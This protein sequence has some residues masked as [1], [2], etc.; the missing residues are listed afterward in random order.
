MWAAAVVLVATMTVT[1]CA[2]GAATG[3]AGDGD[4][5]PRATTT[6]AAST[7]APEA[8]PTTAPAADP[9]AA[10]D[11][12]VVTAAGLSLRQGESELAALDVVAAP[13]DEAVALLT[14]VLGEPRPDGLDESHCRPAQT[15]WGWGAA[16]HIGTPDLYT[17]AGTLTFTAR[18]AAVE[19][20]DGREVR[21]ETTGGLA[22]GDPIAS[23]DAATD[24]TMKDGA[25]DAANH[26]LGIVYDLDRTAEIFDGEWSPHGASVYST[27]GVIEVIRSTSTLKDFC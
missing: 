2:S 17:D 1:G 16:T 6:P 5:S 26:G 18:D 24:A 10:V 9:L 14:R 7:P 11:T 3:E 21:I 13:L 22:V 4:A 15:R 19:T 12:I 8:T 23:L 20:P 27:D 25:S